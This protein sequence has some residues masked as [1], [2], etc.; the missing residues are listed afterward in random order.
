MKVTLIHNPDAGDE[1]PAVDE[2]LGWIRA[3]GHTVTYQ[4]SKSEAWHRAL[5]EPGDLVAVAGGDGIVGSVALRLIGRGIPIAVLP[6]G[7]ANNI[8]NTLGIADT[9]LDRLVSGWAAAHR[10]SFGVGV[11]QGPWGSTHFIEGIGIGLLAKAM[12][13]LDDAALA[14]VDN[15]EGRVRYGLR[16]LRDHLWEY[17]PKKLGITLDGKDL[18]GEHVLLE[19]LNIQHIGPGLHLAPTADPADGVLEVVRFSG[20]ERRDLDNY[21]AS[22]LQVECDP[23]QW[24]IHGGYRLRVKWDGYDLHI[25][26][27]ISPPPDSTALLVPTVIDVKVNRH[28]LEFLV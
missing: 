3:A 18:S 2:L 1:H 6:L 24:T 26:D 16:W 21:L 23:P 10:I 8:S 17:P 15:S 4:S 22:R 14:H 11:V 20:D 13:H 12:T 28:A 9:A 27:K 19:A 7:T 25:D 5:A